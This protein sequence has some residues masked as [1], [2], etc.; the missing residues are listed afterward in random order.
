M[1]HPHTLI[2]FSSMHDIIIASI[3]SY[4]HDEILSRLT[5]SSHTQRGTRDRIP[6]APLMAGAGSCKCCHAHQ[7]GPYTSASTCTVKSSHHSSL[8]AVKQPTVAK[9]QRARQTNAGALQIEMLHTAGD[10]SL[11]C[12]I[13]AREISCCSAKLTE[14]S[15]S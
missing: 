12:T 9:R 1:R 2:S 4:C 6:A 11:M 10:A 13:E 5:H 15:R 7:P 3:I 8:C 14:F